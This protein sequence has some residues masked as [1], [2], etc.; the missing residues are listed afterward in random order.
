[1]FLNKIIQ[2]YNWIKTPFIVLDQWKNGHRRQAIITSTV[3][4]AQAAGT[5]IMWYNPWV[6]LKIVPVF[7]R[8]VEFVL[9]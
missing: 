8:G 4:A 7:I 3:A 2:T 6:I 9:I 5:I 1:M